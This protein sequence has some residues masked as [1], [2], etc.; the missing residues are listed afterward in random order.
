MND[1]KLFLIWFVFKRRFWTWKKNIWRIRY[2]Q[3][4]HLKSIQ[5][6]F[7]SV[8]KKKI[9]E[10]ITMH[11]WILKSFI[12]KY[13]FII[14]YLFG[15]DIYVGVVRTFTRLIQVHFEK[16]KKKLNMFVYLST[17]FTYICFLFTLNTQHSITYR[18][19]Y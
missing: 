11:Y 6:L 1:F 7:S 8:E 9:D 10:S 17:L 13:L 19:V 15:I 12:N 16:K 14:S 2:T 3:S 18:Y 5:T 4:N